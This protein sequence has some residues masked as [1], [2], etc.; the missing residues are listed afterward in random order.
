MERE[1]SRQG[2]TYGWRKRME[3]GLLAG[4]RQKK[5]VSLV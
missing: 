4:Q 5:E 3:S 2:K 1:V